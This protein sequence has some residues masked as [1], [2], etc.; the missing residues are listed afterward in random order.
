MHEKSYQGFIALIRSGKRL[1]TIFDRKLQEHEITLTQC[2]VILSLAD[3]GSVR[4]MDLA[5]QVH[6][7]RNTLVP[8]LDRL[9]QQGWIK[10]QDN[11]DDQRSFFVVLTESGKKRAVSVRGL[12]SK[13]A[14]ELSQ[15][16]TPKE[17]TSAIAYLDKLFK[18][19][20]EN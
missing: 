16:M 14:T 12:I 4:Q 17:T 8:M 19:I 6:V 20:E 10:R 9:E 13:I 1:S 2:E 3:S 7:K 5:E 11:P 18:N 15:G